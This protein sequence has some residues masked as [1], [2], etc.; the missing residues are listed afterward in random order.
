M[1]QK[2]FKCKKRYL[3]IIVK[4]DKNTIITYIFF[5]LKTYEQFRGN[6]HVIIINILNF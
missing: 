2:V 3:Y 4:T 5:I 6:I 1:V